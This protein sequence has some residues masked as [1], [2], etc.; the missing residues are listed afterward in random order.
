MA[1]GSAPT[2]SSSPAPAPLLQALWPHCC[3]GLVP[4]LHLCISLERSSP[5][6][7]H[8]P[9]LILQ[10][11]A[12]KSLCQ[13]G[14]PT[15]PFNLGPW[16]P[17]SPPLLDTP[18]LA[19]GFF[20]QIPYHPPTPIIILFLTFS[21]FRLFQLESQLFESKAFWWFTAVAQVP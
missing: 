20:F 19:L 15:A 13:Q 11:F 6:Y 16:L 10:A 3:P 18:D 4:T 1:H 17:P 5:E 9:L 8:C 7:L 2:P 12:H 14:Y 21:V